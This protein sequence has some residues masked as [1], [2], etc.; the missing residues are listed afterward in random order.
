[1]T[2][3]TAEKKYCPRCDRWYER[4]NFYTNRAHP[5]GYAAYCKP[6]D[7]AK[8]KA[9]RSKNKEGYFLAGQKQKRTRNHKLTNEEF[10]LMLEN[11]NGKCAICK[12]KFT[13]TPVIDHDHSCCLGRYSCGKCTR[14]LLCGNCNRG[15]G[16]FKDNLDTMENAIKYLKN[17]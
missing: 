5:D 12:N 10:N 14:G 9:R 8:Q 16:Q 17:S 1:M 6:C 11:Q 4:N 15:L 13:S 2:K 3:N 7:I